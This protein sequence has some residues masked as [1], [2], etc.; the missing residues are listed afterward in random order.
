[1]TD[2]SNRSTTVK[3]KDQEQTLIVFYNQMFHIP[4][5]LDNHCVP[6]VRLSEDLSDVPVADA[7]VFH[8]PTVREY[9]PIK[10]VG[11]LW[12]VWS[13]ESET[14]YPIINDARFDLTM[15]YHKSAHVCVSYLRDCCSAL[16]QELPQAVMPKKDNCV[17]AS[18]IS[19]ESNKSKRLEYLRELS[20]YV[21]IH[22][23]GDFMNNRQI[24]NDLGVESKINTLKDYQ[25]TIAFENSIS[26]DYVTEKFY[27]PLSVG[28]IPIYMGAPNIS[29]FAPADNSYIDV[30]DYES[31]KALASHILK[32]SNDESLRKQYLNWKDKP[33]K[34]SFIEQCSEY[35][36]SP[37]PFVQLANLIKLRQISLSDFIPSMQKGWEINKEKDQYH[38]LNKKLRVK[39]ISNQS[40]VAVLQHINGKNTIATIQKIFRDAYPNSSR[41]IDRDIIEI[42]RRSQCNKIIKLQAS[43]QT[44]GLLP[45]RRIP[46]K[47]LVLLFGPIG[48]KIATFCSH[49][50]KKH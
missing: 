6:G 43:G 46:F 12:V 21:N 16:L 3:N 28:S 11:Q 2:Y 47:K 38:I 26:P 31:P 29:E 35:I 25:F 37:H 20:E 1:M 27:Q 45:D 50:I 24:E 48:H 42:I 13:M 44:R 23:Y 7:V 30:N 40:V 9:P 19:A 10:P 14:N 22:H 39:V 15:T 32:L 34:T 4:L 8:A 41:A 36:D 33:Y 17:V 49:T 18:F 5:E